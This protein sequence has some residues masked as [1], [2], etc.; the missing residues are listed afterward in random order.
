MWARRTITSFFKA[1]YL[2]AREQSLCQIVI[3]KVGAKII[4][5]Y[6]FFAFV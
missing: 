3:E 2:F 5:K 1:I 4:K 6:I